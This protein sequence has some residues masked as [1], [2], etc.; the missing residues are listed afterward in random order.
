MSG[1]KGILEVEY[2]E[3]P[4]SIVS[5]DFSRTLERAY[6]NG[7]INQ[8]NK[9]YT[10]D[11]VCYEDTDTPFKART[12][13]EYEYN[14]K[15][16]IRF[17]ADSNCKGEILSDGRTIQEGS[18]YWVE[19]KPIKWMIDERTNI[20]LSKYLIFSGVQFNKERNYEGDFENTDIYNFMKTYF[21]KDIIP[22]VIDKTVGQSETVVNSIDAD[23]IELSIKRQKDENEQI[24]ARIKAK[25][26][27]LQ[28]L[29]DIQEE[30]RILL[31][32]EAEL[33]AKLEQIQVEIEGKGQ[34]V[35]Q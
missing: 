10:T 12:H 21:S 1:A 14:G 34:Y 35:K 17:V 20:D 8:T 31:A 9:K 32:K 6:S 19:V 13:I 23:S 25:E 33:D 26:Q 15:K 18:P 22:S 7:T 30:K 2:G 24:R 11:S 16:Y 29:S 5:E 28:Q 4:Q 3:Y 27:L